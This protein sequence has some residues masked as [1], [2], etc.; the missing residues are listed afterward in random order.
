LWQLL[1]FS[2]LSIGWVAVVFLT[3]GETVNRFVLT[4]FFGWLPDYFQVTAIFENPVFYPRSNRILIWLLALIF[5]FL[6]GLPG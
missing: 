4:T 6:L 3:V 1:L 5:G 2:A